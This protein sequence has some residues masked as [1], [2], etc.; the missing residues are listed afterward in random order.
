MSSNRIL[1]ILAIV[2]LLSLSGPSAGFAQDRTEPLPNELKEV[3]VVERLGESLPIDRP[4][5]DQDGKRVFLHDF[6]GRGR[7]M[8]LT[9]NYSS[10]PMLCH[11]QRDG[12][13]ETLKQLD[14]MPGRE[15]DIVTIGIDPR[16]TPERAGQTRRA[17]LKAYG[18]PE[19]APG[20]NFLTGREADIR[21]VADA[22]GFGY[23]YVPSRDEYAHSAA[24]VICSPE[25]RVSSYL[26]GI[27]YESAALKQALQ[28][29][30]E[31]KTAATSALDQILM[32]C[33][34]YDP[35]TRRYAPAAMKLMR[36]GAGLSAA[37]FLAFLVR[38]WIRD[39]A[40]AAPPSQAEPL[41][42]E[43]AV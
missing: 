39:Q 30:G 40:V 9:F 3:E 21:A 10:C 15:F 17:T 25:G 32:Y 12:L 22:A 31:G 13:I 18:R 6:F 14:W 33:F 36:L 7:P 23:R 1:C 11:V 2:A 19:A 38:S 42:H 34:H 4:F 41:L 27:R 20:W 35:S 8:V 5:L 28:G 16:E 24:L 43:A 29:A 26:Y 37:A